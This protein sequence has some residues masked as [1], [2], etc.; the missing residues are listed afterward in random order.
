MSEFPTDISLY[1]MDLVNTCA[2]C[3][4]QYNVF[5]DGTQVGYLRLRHGTFRAHAPGVGGDIVYQSSTR[6]DGIF[7]AD[8]RPYELSNAVLA[9]QGWLMR[10]PQQAP[11][12]E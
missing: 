3:P 6:G 12:H 10:H 2:A 11:R 9:I 1:G 4:E 5:K 8:E 7:N